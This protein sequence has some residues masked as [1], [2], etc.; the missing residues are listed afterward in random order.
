METLTPPPS[1][2]VR[3]GTFEVN[4]RT[5][6]LRKRGIR[7]ALQEQPLRILSVL[8]DR[9]GEVVSREDLCTRLWPH[10]T[11]VD[12]EHS[13]NAAVRRLRVTLGDEAEVP[14]FIETVHK[15]GYRFIALNDVFPRTAN[16]GGRPA[17]PATIAHIVRKRARLAVL[18]FG[19][20][21]G[22]THGLTEEA[23][24][25]LAQS[26]P[27]NIGVIARTSVER[28]QREG[29]GA[30]EIGRALSADYL[31][32][33]SVRRDGDRLRITAQLIEAQEETH[34]WAKTFDRVMTDALTLQTEVAEEI[35][36]AVTE[37]LTPVRRPAVPGLGN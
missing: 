24:S 16:P 36:R 37:T 8:L 2:I 26:C 17:S 12:F 29:G 30:A 11:Y 10:G 14:R 22:F 9:A 7:I 25:Q 5:G 28:A 34:L 1:D 33:G 3:F 32:E 31:V 13:L 19:P 20:F 6:E 35:A 23:I 15:R 4:L 18:P 21:D 27:R